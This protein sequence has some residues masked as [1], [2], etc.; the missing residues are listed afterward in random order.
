MSSREMGK[1]MEKAV[2]GVYRKVIYGMDPSVMLPMIRETGILTVD[3]YEP[4]CDE[5]NKMIQHGRTIADIN[6]RLL[7]IL[8]TRDKWWIV[9]IRVCG[10]C[11]YQGII[12]AI[13]EELQKKESHKGKMT[14]RNRHTTTHNR[15]ESKTGLTDTDL[16]FPS[17]NHSSV[18]QSSR[19]R[20]GS[21]DGSLANSADNDKT[22]FPIRPSLNGASG[23]G[24][25][26]ASGQTDLSVA[27]A[28]NRTKQT[29]SDNL[30]CTYTLD[31]PLG[32]APG[33]FITKLY[34][35]LDSETRMGNYKDL[36]GELGFTL[37]ELSA[38]VNTE[39]VIQRFSQAHPKKATFRFPMEALDKLERKDVLEDI[40]RLT[41]LVL[42]VQEQE[43][44]N[45]T[46]N[47]TRTLDRNC[48]RMLGKVPDMC[49]EVPDDP[50]VI[51]SDVTNVTQQGGFSPPS[52]INHKN[53][54]EFHGSDAT[55]TSEA[56]T[57]TT[58]KTDHDKTSENRVIEDDLDTAVHLE[59][60]VIA[61]YGHK[62][63]EYLGEHD[64]RKIT[65]TDGMSDIPG[66]IDDGAK[67]VPI[68]KVLPCY[69]GTGTRPKLYPGRHDQGA[70]YLSPENINGRPTLKQLSCRESNN[71]ESFSQG[72]T[73]APSLENIDHRDQ[74]QVPSHCSK[75]SPG[76]ANIPN[77]S[78]ILPT[79]KERNENV[80]LEGKHSFNAPEY[81]HCISW[82][83]Y[84]ENAS[85]HDKLAKEVL[86]K[87]EL[88]G[89]HR[90]ERQGSDGRSATPDKTPRYTHAN[91][92]RGTVGANQGLELR[93][94]QMYLGPCLPIDDSESESPSMSGTDDER[95]DEM[96]TGK[97]SLGK[98]EGSV[99]QQRQIP[100]G[101]ERQMASSLLKWK[102]CLMTLAMHVHA[103]INTNTLPN[104][105]A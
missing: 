97:G 102:R 104:W 3:G 49:G 35:H 21:D 96:D 51:P 5:L 8:F 18:L 10:Q 6:T 100:V 62:A 22:E 64:N 34:Q 85:V 26:L 16:A 99:I 2:K 60:T 98:S 73:H 37:D 80:A 19:S 81:T 74:T 11:G 31:T 88:R 101:V 55:K 48:E 1:V 58:M 71:E 15:H 27:M 70:I 17:A 63:G 36:A 44:L 93:K 89:G 68:P 90:L 79:K 57:I 9:F 32:K 76:L 39:G 78:D 59:E 41:G 53:K 69:S 50:G 46:S 52:N 30:Q 7:D 95:G 61:V 83:Q 38:L 65:A 23:C 40:R 67:P 66:N 105:Y 94:T 33:T 92:T 75:L 20:R 86:E 12:Q 103:G 13:E 45:G 84:S 14:K 82:S 77:F 29:S 54:M 87:Q 56:I 28:Q 43:E 4:Y 72:E 91:H 24:R 42:Q 47:S 25:N